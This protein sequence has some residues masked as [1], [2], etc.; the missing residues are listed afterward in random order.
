MT[1]RN[2]AAE[3][4]KTVLALAATFAAI[5]AFAYLWNATKER[6]LRFRPG[7]TRVVRRSDIPAYWTAPFDTVKT[8]YSQNE[9]EAHALALQLAQEEWGAQ[10]LRVEV[11]PFIKILPD[12]DALQ[13]EK[14]E[15]NINSYDTQLKITPR[16]KQFQVSVSDPA[17]AGQYRCV[18]RADPPDGPGWR[19]VSQT[20]LR[21]RCTEEGRTCSDEELLL[22]SRQ[23]LTWTV[24]LT[25]TGNESR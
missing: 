12:D 15:W 14:E 16:V 3:T 2:N 6:H 22:G 11:P 21:E 25:I 8:A 5:L 23:P 10:R 1:E 20:S 4:T 24:T 19:A 9:S 18:F 7:E 13:V 17:P